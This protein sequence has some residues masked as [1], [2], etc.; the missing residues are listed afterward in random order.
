MTTHQYKRLGLPTDYTSLSHTVNDCIHK[1]LEF[2]EKEHNA[3]S[4]GI[5][6]DA[7]NLTSEH[8]RLATKRLFTRYSCD[9]N[10]IKGITQVF[11]IFSDYRNIPFF[12]FVVKV[13]KS[14]EHPG[15]ED[16]S[17]L[18]QASIDRVLHLREAMPWPG[19]ILLHHRADQ[20]VFSVDTIDWAE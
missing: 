15:Y 17:A 12:Y 6:A 10:F 20:S 3:E 8:E 4:N 11:C 19:L 5:I 18:P 7:L 16:G 14:P 13:H 2:F 1:D 9:A